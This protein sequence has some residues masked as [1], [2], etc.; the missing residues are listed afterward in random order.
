MTVPA[1]RLEAVALSD[2]GGVRSLNEDAVVADAALGVSMVAD[3]MGGHHAGEVASRMAVEGLLSSLSTRIRQYRAGARRPT[4]AQFVEQ[5]VTEANLAIH[6]AACAD[7]QCAGMGTTLALALFLE[8]RAVLAHAGDSR[9]YRLRNGHLQLLTRDDSML[10]DQIALG[11]IDASEAGDSHNRH[12]VTR[13]LGAA[14][15]IAVNLCEEPLKV[16]DVFLLCSD[17]LSDLVEAT[18][19]ELVVDSL[20]TNLPLAAAHL[21]D[22]ANDLGGYDNISVVLVRVHPAGRDG[23]EGNWLRRLFGWLRP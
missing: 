16:G 5:A 3:G 20:K 4:P 22:L 6:R 8:D 1:Y 12:L 23:A 15:R 19:L 21:V 9:I 10:S 13:A 17:G 2:P 18:D 11:L 14:K 7:E